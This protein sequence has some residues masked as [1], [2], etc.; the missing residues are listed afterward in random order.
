MP[1]S[2]KIPRFDCVS[3][4]DIGIG[5]GQR[6]TDPL[7]P[8]MHRQSKNDRRFAAI[9][10]Y[11]HHSPPSRAPSVFPTSVGMRWNGGGDK[12]GR[13]EETQPRSRLRRREEFRRQEFRRQEFRCLGSRTNGGCRSRVDAAGSTDTSSRSACWKPWVGQFARPE[14]SGHRGDSRWRPAALDWARTPDR[15]VW[16]LFQVKVM[17]CSG[18][19]V[20]LSSPS[21]CWLWW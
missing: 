10:T 8:G 6:A 11:R 9:A 13:V 17:V 20:M 19:P 5:A 21:W 14:P 4:H 15:A 7:T 16:P 12:V 3:V 18:L 1:R 2:P